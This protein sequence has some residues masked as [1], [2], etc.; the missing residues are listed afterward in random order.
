MTDQLQLFQQRAA[1]QQAHELDE[2]AVL[3]T[4]KQYAN[5]PEPQRWAKG[6]DL[7]DALGW[8]DHENS[9][10]KLRKIA[11][12][13]PTRIVSGDDGYCLLENATLKEVA[14]CCR[15]LA[16]QGIKNFRRAMKTRH[17]YHQFLKSGRE[18]GSG[19]SAATGKA[20]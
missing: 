7:I 5:L 18:C 20:A 9:R 10:R 12:Q 11:E 17:A 8:P 19:L 3:L 6:K 2:R 4:L 16:S 1:R 14:H 15:R 13:N